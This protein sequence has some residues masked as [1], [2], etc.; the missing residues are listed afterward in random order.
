M[1][2]T[3]R[4]IALLMALLMI[5]P[6]LFACGDTP[7]EMTDAPEETKSPAESEAEKSRQ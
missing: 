6:M 5:V 1:K 7:E 4:S 3:L 2:K